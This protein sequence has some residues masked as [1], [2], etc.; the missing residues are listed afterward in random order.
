MTQS[1]LVMAVATL[2][3]GCGGPDNPLEAASAN[4]PTLEEGEAEREIRGGVE[5]EQPID[6]PGQRQLDEPPEG[7]EGGPPPG[8]PDLGDK[9]K[10]PQLGEEG[11]PPF[12]GAPEGEPKLP[13]LAE[14]EDPSG[15]LLG[16]VVDGEGKDVAGAKVDVLGVDATD[17]TDAQGLFRVPAPQTGLPVLRVTRSGYKPTIAVGAGPEGEHREVRVELESTAAAEAAFTEA[18]GVGM[19]A[20]QGTVFLHVDAGPKP[21]AGLTASLTASGATPWIY[22][23][24]DALVQGGAIRADASANEIVFPNVAVGNHTLTVTAPPGWSC[25]GPSSV[26][27]EKGTFSAV[28]WRCG[29]DA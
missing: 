13:G 3:F 2:L 29:P 16:K 1:W 20:A 22:D 25:S 14:G 8:E 12:K 6:R 21:V 15:T 7:E 10:G 17:E 4:E 18:F 5:G 24:E 26:P 9:P 11:G 28:F 19:N 27:V 23:A